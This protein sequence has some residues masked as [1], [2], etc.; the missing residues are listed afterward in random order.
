M[1]PKLKSYNDVSGRQKR[2]RRNCE[3]TLEG[4][5]KMKVSEQKQC[6]L[7]S[8]SSM[9]SVGDDC[10]SF[11]EP[12]VDACSNLSMSSITSIENSSRSVHSENIGSSS[13]DMHPDNHTL[14]NVKPNELNCENE[15]KYSTHTVIRLKNIL[16]QW[17]EN[18]PRLSAGCVERLLYSINGIFPEVPKTV[19]GL[20]IRGDNTG[21]FLREMGP[22][23]YVHFPSWI[24]GI[25]DF[26]N[27]QSSPINFNHISLCVNIDG[28]PLFDRT[29][30]YS[31][32]PILCSI[33]ECPSK[34]FCAGIYCTT[35]F[36]N[37]SLP[38]ADEFLS[39]FLKDVR[40]LE[41]GILCE[42]SENGLI[43][44]CICAFVC[45]APMRAFLKDIISH[46]GHNSCE[47]CTVAGTY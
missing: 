26:I 37:K 38:T 25:K 8:N 31:A 35:N 1:P 44:C 19:K 13:E 22:G 20:L 10:P 24:S 23:Q 15:I 18:E 7:S 14:M 40:E 4:A 34:I 29:T 30:K 16:R 46:T 17:Y 3:I 39:E 5:K 32:Y 47:R 41:N 42:S 2:R 33:L 27:G 6:A 21:Y 11:Q 43:T 36:N 12:Y 9:A 45:D 28:L